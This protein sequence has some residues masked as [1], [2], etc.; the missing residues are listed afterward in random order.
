MFER[1]WGLIRLVALAVAAGGISASAAEEPPVRDPNLPWLDNEFYK[2]LIDLRARIE[3]ADQDSLDASQAYTIRT[4]A[5]IQAKPYHGFSALAELSNTWSLDDGAYY[6]G[7]SSPNGKTT[8]ADPETTVLNRAW[9][10]FEKPEWLGVKAKGGRQRIIFDDA[11]F[12]GN[13]GWRQKEQTFDA[14]LGQTNLSVEDLTVQYGYLWDIRR[15]FGDQGLTAVGA[16]DFSSDSHLARVNY[17]GLDFLELT[18]FVYLL[19]FENDSPG[20]SANTYGLR[21]W[22]RTEIGDDLYLEYAG[23][24]AFQTDAADNPANYDAHYVWVSGDLGMDDL[25][26]F[27]VGYE[28]LGSDD[29][30]GRVI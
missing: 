22:G 3:L 11:R 20:N 24:Y 5:G 7:A 13:V 6:D 25:G 16:R 18:A 8:I 26:S 17:T 12:I 19:D 9:L 28:L 27:G 1:R 29:G 4:R 14:A 10:G 23:S 21:G 30:D 15:I 2:V